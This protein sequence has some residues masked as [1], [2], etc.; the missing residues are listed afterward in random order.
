MFRMAFVGLGLSLLTAPALAGPAA[1]AVRYFYSPVTSESDPQNRERFT[2]PAKKIFEQNDAAVEGG[3]EIG[4]IDFALAVDAQ[5]LDDGE[6]SRTLRLDEKV[7]GGDAT[8]T[9]YFNLFPGEP[10]SKREIVWTLKKV[11][12]DWKVADIESPQNQW[13]LSEFDCA[14]R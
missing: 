14:P 12:G 9:A 6:V 8:V 10:E 4:C 7:S 2:D 11:G 13:K 1:D 3:E 5:D